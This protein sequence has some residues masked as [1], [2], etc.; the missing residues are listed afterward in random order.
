MNKDC[1]EVLQ[2]L[3]RDYSY[4]NIFD[5]MMGYGDATAA[6]Y[7]DAQDEIAKLTYRETGQEA[8]NAAAALLEAVDEPKGSFIGLKMENSPHW[9]SAFWGIL[10]AGFQPILLDVRA[11]PEATLNLLDQAGAVGIITE[12]DAG[13]YLGYEVLRLESLLEKQAAPDF[14]PDWADRVALCTSGTTGTAKVFVYDGAAMGH[15]MDNA[16]YFLGY[17]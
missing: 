12:E 15:Q 1:L 11:E 5:I 7:L 16:R 13:E 9:P 14:A 6:E 8:R 10:M 2:K 3:S 4:R 17:P